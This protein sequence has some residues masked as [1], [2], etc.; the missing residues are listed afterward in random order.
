M[1][2]DDAQPSLGWCSENTYARWIIVRQAPNGIREIGAW[3]V[4]QHFEADS[5]APIDLPVLTRGITRCWLPILLIMQRLRVGLIHTERNFDLLFCTVSRWQG[6]FVRDAGLR[7]V[8]SSGNYRR[9]LLACSKKMGTRTLS[10]P[11]LSWYKKT[12]KNRLWSFTSS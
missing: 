5:F 2:T 3:S 10:T 9:A 8:A 1:R 6:L 12:P 11:H 7:F 4:V